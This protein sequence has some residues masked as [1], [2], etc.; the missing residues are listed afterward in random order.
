[1]VA[2]NPA[3]LKTNINDLKQGGVIIV[4]GAAFNDLALAKASYQS[5]PLEDQS[6][7]DY[8]VL[9]IDMNGILRRALKETSLQHAR[10]T[11]M[12]KKCSFAWDYFFGCIRE[13]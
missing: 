11:K 6:L 3:A 1:M 2:L 10:F 8:Q 5:N 13:T 9:S 4:N 12:R 7:L